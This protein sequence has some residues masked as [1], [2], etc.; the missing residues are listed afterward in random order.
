[1]GSGGINLLARDGEEDDDRPGNTGPVGLRA[2][3]KSDLTG[4]VRPRRAA[5]DRRC[6]GK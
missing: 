4:D 6:K 1:M 5:I 3:G 2:M